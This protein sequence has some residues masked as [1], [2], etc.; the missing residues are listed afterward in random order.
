MRVTGSSVNMNRR[1]CATSARISIEVKE[2][3][4]SLATPHA[5]A[6]ASMPTLRD[7]ATPVYDAA[8]R[9]DGIIEG[10]SNRP[11]RPCAAASAA[12]A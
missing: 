1:D 6:V 12:L 10:I 8:I 5:E 3:R 2:N 11:T 4:F 9:P 7:R